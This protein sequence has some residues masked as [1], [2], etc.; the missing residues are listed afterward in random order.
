MILKSKV[1]AATIEDE[2]MNLHDEEQGII[3]NEITDLNTELRALVKSVPLVFGDNVDLTNLQIDTNEVLTNVVKLTNDINATNEENDQVGIILS[4]QILTDTI[5]CQIEKNEKTDGSGMLVIPEEV[6][7]KDEGSN[8]GEVRNILGALKVIFTDEEGNVNV[9]LEQIDANIIVELDDDKLDT[10]FTSQV[11]LATFYGNLH[12]LVD[13]DLNGVLYIKEG[14]KENKEE[15]IQFI[16]SI[17]VVFEATNT[18]LNTMSASTFDINVFMEFD[19]DQIDTFLASS[20]ISYSAAYQVLPILSEGGALYDY[21]KLNATTEEDKVLEVE[22]DLPNLIR[23]IRDLKADGIPYDEF[24]FDAFETAINSATEGLPANATLEE[25][26]AAKDSKADSIAETLLQSQILTQSLDKMFDK[27]LSETLSSEYMELVQLPLSSNPETSKELWKGNATD[28]GE[29]KRIMRVVASIN[30]FAATGAD[31][32]SID[33]PEE[34]TIP[35][36]KVNHSLVLHGLLPKFVETATAN[37]DS[38]RRVD[39]NGDYVLPETVE[40]WDDEIDVLA[41]LIIEVK[42]VDLASLEVTGDNAVD[43]NKLGTI[44]YLINDSIMI[45]IEKVVEPLEAGVEAVFEVDVTLGTV[46]P[47]DGQS[48]HDAWDQEIAQIVIV[49]TKLQA[50]NELSL[51]GTNGV[52][53]ANA[54]GGFLDAASESQL[55]EPV[56]EEV[57]NKIVGPL[58]S[59]PYVGAI[60]Q[61]YLDAEGTYTE[62][63]VKIAELIS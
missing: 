53:N 44:L 42:E 27:I 30:T 51:E 34:L 47:S 46:T 48:E 57:V 56:V 61:G 14:T 31:N 21:A 54:I 55:L 17:Q 62:K 40:A 19:D 39:A 63:L 9:D 38:W 25:I 2:L 52:A 59:M 12:E 41:N 20:I 4:S 58:L 23:V 26:N 3:V 28:E 50:I 16:Q 49:V 37:V 10:A 32:S 13:G 43:P 18:D 7:W 45:D 5:I 60:I 15:A 1:L 29:L 8:A 36:K 33:N 11:M 22:E 35:L 24:N 6:S